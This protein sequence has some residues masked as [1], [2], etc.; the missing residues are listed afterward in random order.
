MATGAIGAAAASEA[1]FD[2]AEYA[3]LSQRWLAVGYD[4]ELAAGPLAA[5]LLGHDLVVVDLDGRLLATVDRCAHRGARLSP[6]AVATSPSGEACLVCPYHGLHIDAAGR[7]V[8]LPARPDDRLPGRLALRTYPA[9]IRHGVVWVC[10]SDE[11]DGDPPDWSAYDQP[12]RLRFQLDRATWQAMPTRI[13]ENFNDLAHF[14]T[15]HAGTFGDPDHPLVPDIGLGS[16]GDDIRHAVDM[17]QLDRV[18]LDGPLV[19][20][21]VRFSYVHRF[22]LATELEI[23]YGP[24]RTEWIQ[25]VVSPVGPTTSLVLQQNVR[26]FDLDGDVGAWHDFQAAVNEED[27][28]VLEGLTPRRQ[29]IAETGTNEVALS[30]DSFTIAFRRRWAAELGAAGQ[31]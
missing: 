14:A 4:T 28:V 15:V 29:S 24:D 20:I 31:S 19:P 13:V 18:T 3:A 26:N 10:L 21:E 22:P 7:P 23:I 30:V 1:A 11:P 2:P 9:Q 25:M 17:H 5:R 8:H 16:D 27:Q 12:E 6:G